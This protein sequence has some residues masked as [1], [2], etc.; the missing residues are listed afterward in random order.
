[1]E[2]HTALDFERGFPRHGWPFPQVQPPVLQQA[3]AGVA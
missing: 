1:M 2:P 3:E